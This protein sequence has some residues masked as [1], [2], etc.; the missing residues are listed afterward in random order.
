MIALGEARRVSRNTNKNISVQCINKTAFLSHIQPPSNTL[1]EHLC[2]LLALF[3][4]LL[5]TMK[6]TKIALGYNWLPAWTKS[7]TVVFH[8]TI[9]IMVELE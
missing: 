4:L 6:L 2:P 9:E 5:T 8:F 7:I 1:Q 3:L